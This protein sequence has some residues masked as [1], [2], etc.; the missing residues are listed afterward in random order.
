MVTGEQLVDVYLESRRALELESRGGALVR[1]DEVVVR[2]V[3]SVRRTN[4]GGFELDAVWTVGGSVNHF[5]HEHFRQNRYDAFI[6]VVPSGDTWKIAGVELI[7]E[8]RVL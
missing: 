3:R 1:T 7:D 2:D 8:R 5:G 6:T 4:D